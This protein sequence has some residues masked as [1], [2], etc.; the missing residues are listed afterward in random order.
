MNRISQRNILPTAIKARGLGNAIGITTTLETSDTLNNGEDTIF[1]V[2]IENNKSS[3]IMAEVE[4]SLWQTSV[5][6]ANLIPNGSSIDASDYQIIG[7]W[8]E[9]REFALSG[10]NVTK[11]MP[12]YA[13]VNRLYV[14]NIAAGASTVI[15]AKARVRYLTSLDTVSIT[16]ET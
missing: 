11:T 5:T 14:R 2:V 13:Q 16:I 10:Q 1:S 8:N 9:W 12:N 4:W 6:D 3:S 15:E 7:P